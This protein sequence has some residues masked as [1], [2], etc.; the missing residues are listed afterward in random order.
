VTPGSLTTFG[1]RHNECEA[2]TPRW[3]GSRDTGQIV[4]PGE[5]WGSAATQ[6]G[7]FA[8]ESRRL[9]GRAF[10]GEFDHAPSARVAFVR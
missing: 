4:H 3:R 7:T 8:L 6:R 1:R 2:E 10:R 9:A 5:H